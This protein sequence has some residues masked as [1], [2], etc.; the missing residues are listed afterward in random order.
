METEWSPSVHSSS[1]SK[2]HGQ[3]PC[4]P[5]PKKQQPEGV[6]DDRST[7]QHLDTFPQHQQYLPIS[8]DSAANPS[9]ESSGGIEGCASRG[10]AAGCSNNAPFLPPASLHTVPGLKVPVMIAYEA[11]LT[12]DPTHFSGLGHRGICSP[13][14]IKQE[15]GQIPVALDMQ[16]QLMSPPAPSW[17]Q[18]KQQPVAGSWNG[19][20]LCLSSCNLP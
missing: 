5:E 8:N 15:G 7:A 4:L 20:S 19:A 18:S 10:P 6:G 13:Q 17:R 11:D 3:G 14:L 9:C 1:A 12:K 16:R 2:P